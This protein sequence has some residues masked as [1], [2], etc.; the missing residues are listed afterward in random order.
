MAV[1]P[2]AV[3]VHLALPVDLVPDV[4]AGL[5]DDPALQLRR[6][7]VPPHV[8]VGRE[9]LLADAV[10][11]QPLRGDSP[12]DRLDVVAPACHARNLT[13]PRRTL[14][15]VRQPLPSPHSIPF[16]PL[17][18]ATPAVARRGRAPQPSFPPAACRPATRRRGQPGRSEG[19]APG[20]SLRRAASPPFRSMP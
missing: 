7:H 2:V 6:A 16:P 9:L 20:G 8:D 18:A 14:Q 15:A 10:V 13:P 1:H 4:F 17:P 11:P 19:Q 3:A 12:R 5:V